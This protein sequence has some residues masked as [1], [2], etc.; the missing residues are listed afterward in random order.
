M[1]RAREVMLQSEAAGPPG[2]VDLIFACVQ[3]VRGDVFVG[4]LSSYD[5]EFLPFS[6][7]ASR[8]VPKCR[9]RCWP[10]GS[11]EFL[12][13][14]CDKLVEPEADPIYSGARNEGGG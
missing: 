3:A 4:R 13:C 14:N 2:K 5:E 8:Q 1:V 9:R 11:V 7:G 10:V 12:S 6:E